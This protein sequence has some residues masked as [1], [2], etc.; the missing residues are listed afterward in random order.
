MKKRYLLIPAAVLLI[1]AAVL[2]F[3][4]FAGGGLSMEE[5]E[6]R[7]YSGADGNISLSWPETK[8]AEY[9]L[10]VRSEN[11][12][13]SEEEPLSEPYAEL[14]TAGKSFEVRI[15]AVDPATG[16]RSHKRNITIEATALEAPELTAFVGKGEASLSWTGGGGSFYEVSSLDSRTALAELEGTS[17]KLQFAPEGDLELPSDEQPLRVAVRA[18]VPGKG[19]VFYG[20]PSQ[21]FVIRREAL[22]NDAVELT[23]QETQPRMYTLSWQEGRGTHYEVQEWRDGEWQLL[24]RFTPPGANQYETGRLASGSHH[25]LRVVSFDASGSVLASE[26]TEF[27]AAVHPLYAT[28]WPILDLNLCKDPNGK[29]L[30]KISAG[31][32]LCVLEEKDG[33]FQVRHG[34]DYGYVDSRYCMINLAEYLGDYCAYDITNSYSSIFKVHNSPIAKITRQV[35]P[36]YEHIQTAEGFLVP[37]LYPCA[38]KL[39]SAAKAA[40]EDGYRLRIY[41]AYRPNQTTR[42]LYDTTAAQLYYAALVEKGGYCVD[43][44]LNCRVDLATGLYTDPDTG[45]QV[46]RSDL[47]PEPKPEPEPE[48]EPPAA[49]PEDGQTAE[50]PAPQTPEEEPTETPE[51]PATD[52]QAPEDPSAG[53]Q[54]PEDPSAGVQAPE[55]PSADIQAPEDPSAG[56]QAPEDPS[57]GV[58]APENPPPVQDAP[59]TT[60]TAAPEALTA[61]L[62]LYANGNQTKPQTLT[63]S[64][65]AYDTYF[66]L[67]TDNGRFGLGSFLARVTSAHNRGIA[68]DLTLETLA[69]GKALA[70]QSEMHD[71][72]WYS[73]V[74]RNND[75]AKRLE[76]YMTGVGMRGLSSEWWHFQDDA[77]REAIKLNT[78]LSKGVDASGWTRDDQG[79][80]WRNESGVPQKNTSIT[81]D[82]VRWTLDSNGY[83]VE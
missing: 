25:H 45:K 79:W 46:L 12:S 35:I 28:I 40:L 8:G 29:T 19:Y 80:R 36:G 81:V 59:D 58:Q 4:Q 27:Y 21:A 23:C 2:V 18:G 5:G 69:D 47:I 20:P 76:K 9:R 3:R 34:N 16:K 56:A 60:Q 13:W 33:W 1:A 49:P 11:G 38:Q 48:P 30:K 6:V 24:E 65:P 83:V 78:Y 67:M 22:L 43:P 82:G 71:L 70:M 64:L 75:N 74:Y 57:A 77:T 61:R 44:Q 51:E 63:Q 14:G 41:E 31:T 7:V 26:E 68:L 62:L 53:V 37:Y 66:K 39:L 73:A 17:L 32:S 55:D 72:S 42:Y 52:V 10:S 54:A 50:P 15:Q